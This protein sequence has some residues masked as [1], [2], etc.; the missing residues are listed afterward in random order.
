M[1][2]QNFPKICRLCFSVRCG[3]GLYRSSSFPSFCDVEDPLNNV[4]RFP[5]VIGTYTHQLDELNLNTRNNRPCS[6]F[7][8]HLNVI[9][10]DCFLATRYERL[11]KKNAPRFLVVG[12]NL[13][14]HRHSAELLMESNHRSFCYSFFLIGRRLPNEASKET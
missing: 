14:T 2:G 10:S 6:A 8:N 4:F 11:K 1:V 9:R 13:L 12:A 7:K 3:A 5:S